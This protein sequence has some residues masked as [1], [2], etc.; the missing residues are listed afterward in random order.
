VFAAMIFDL[1]GVIAD[2]HPIHRQAWRQLL[3]EQRHQ[4]TEEQLD[5]VLEGRTRREILHHFF[6]SLS[7]CEISHFG[8]RKDELFYESAAGLRLRAIPGVIDFLHQL[9][10]AGVPKAVA[11]SASK[12]RA[13]HVLELLGVTNRFCAVLTGNDIAAAKPD[14][15]IFYLAA[16]RLN[17]KPQQSLVAEDSLAGICA[18]KSAGMR[19]L[20]IGTGAL[21]S[22]L[23]QEGADHVT[24]D[25]NGVSVS[26]L[27][28]LFLESPRFSGTD[29]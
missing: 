4:V 14:P 21:S 25:F 5:F 1:D 19:C 17:V 10:S 6:G 28:N 23:C 16:N 18:A 24:P 12:R 13:H 7:V 27:Q 26:Q 3:L 22:R 15:S 11:T 8:K 9:E 20:G 29:H 2:T